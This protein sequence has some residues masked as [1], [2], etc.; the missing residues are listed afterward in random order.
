MYFGCLMSR[1]CFFQ[2]VQR[3]HFLIHRAVVC[4]FHPGFAR[5]RLHFKT[6]RMWTE[7]T[8]SSLASS[9]RTVQTLTSRTKTKVF[10]SFHAVKSAHGDME[11]GLTVLLNFLW[12]GC[13]WKSS[14]G[15]SNLENPP[16]KAPQEVMCKVHP[17]CGQLVHLFCTSHQVQAMGTV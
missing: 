8:D 15:R 7:S 12:F 13:T 2:T 11:G 10:R 16:A 17:P 1:I 3:H 14:F 4:H 5:S 9:S 6:S